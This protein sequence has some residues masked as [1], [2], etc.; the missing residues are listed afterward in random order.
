MFIYVHRTSQMAEIVRTLME[1]GLT[2]T[3][4]KHGHGPEHFSTSVGGALVEIYP[5]AG[6]RPC[7]QCAGCIVE[8]RP[9]DVCRTCLEKILL[10]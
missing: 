6:E 3:R 8:D 2:M 7:E 1:R 10:G 5:P 9:S 4:E